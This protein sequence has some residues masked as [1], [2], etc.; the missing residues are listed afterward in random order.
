[1]TKRKKE[2]LAFA[3]SV[4]LILNGANRKK[5][6]YTLPVE[7]LTLESLEENKREKNKELK[8]RKRVN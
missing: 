3:L 6:D 2:I 7:P 4:G 5:V 8:L 1:M